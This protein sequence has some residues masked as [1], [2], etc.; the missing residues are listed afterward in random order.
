MLLFYF[1]NDF[2]E[3]HK[4]IQLILKDVKTKRPNANFFHYDSFDINIEN[5]KELI[6]SQGLFENKNIVLLTNLFINND[7]K[8]FILENIQEFENS[9]SAFIFSEEK[10]S[11]AEQKEIKKTALKF[12]EFKKNEI[13]QENLFQISDYLQKKDK[14]KLWTFYQESF[15]KGADADSMYNVIFWSMK[16]LALAEIFSEK[17]SGLKPFPYK[18]AKS[19]LKFWKKNEISEKMFELLKIHSE[20]RRGILNLKNSLEKFLLEL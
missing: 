18:K 20:S 6:K 19:S 11:A 9:E 12:E 13:R 2:N 14:K 7:L 8:K 16:T 1:G 17:E 10:I 5:L 4:K 15:E 3:R